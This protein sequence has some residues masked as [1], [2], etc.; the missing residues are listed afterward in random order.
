MQRIDKKNFCFLQVPA[1]HPQILFAQAGPGLAK[2]RHQPKTGGEAPRGGG[3]QRL[4]GRPR[5][6]LLQPDQP[7]LRDR[8]RAVHGGHLPDHVRGAKVRVPV[9]GW[10]KV[11]EANAPA[12]KPGIQ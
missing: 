8:L 10:G 9:A 1:G 6:R 4:A 2:L 3:L 12:R 5:R 11:Q 7:H